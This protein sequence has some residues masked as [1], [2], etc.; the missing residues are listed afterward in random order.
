MRDNRSPYWRQRRAA[1]ALGGRGRDG[2]PLIGPPGR[3]GRPHRFFTA[4]LG[5]TA[6]G[7]A[8]A[9][10]VAVAYA[11]ALACSARS[12]RSAR[13][14]CHRPTRGTGPSGCSAARSARTGSGASTWPTIPASTTPRARVVSAGATAT[15]ERRRHGWP[16]G[17]RHAR[18]TGRRKRADSGAAMCPG[19]SSPSPPGRPGRPRQSRSNSPSWAPATNASHSA[20]VKTSTGPSGS[21]ELR[22]PIRSSTKA[23]STALSEVSPSARCQTAR[24]RSKSPLGC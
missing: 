14:P 5:F 20:W 15:T 12:W 4:H 1:E 21:A 8:D 7:P 6:P 2:R 17:R 3:P 9:R 16:P 24:E 13:R 10:E 22:I 23:T 11:E 18:T 19:V